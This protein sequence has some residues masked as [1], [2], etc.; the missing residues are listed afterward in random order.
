[1]VKTGAGQACYGRAMTG[2]LSEFGRFGGVG[3]AAAVAHYG[4][5]IL[6]VEAFAIGPT[7]AALAGF[8][9]GGLVSYVLNHRWTFRSGRAHVEAVPRFMAIAAVG[10]G[11][12][13]ALMSLLADRFA[14]PYLAAQLITTA[15]VLVWHYVANKIVTFGRPTS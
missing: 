8:V 15:I 4:T 11:L 6:L 3:V 14:V 9:A 13:W 10:F 2:L 12:T 7:P 1:M 5:L